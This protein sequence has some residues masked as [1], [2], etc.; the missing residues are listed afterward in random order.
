M[1]PPRRLVSYISHENSMILLFLTSKV[2]EEEKEGWCTYVF[3]Y[4]LPVSHFSYRR[5]VGGLE[6]EILFIKNQILAMP[7][8]IAVWLYLTIYK[9]IQCN[10]L[11]TCLFSN[12]FPSILKEYFSKISFII[13]IASLKRKKDDLRIR[14]TFLKPRCCEPPGHYLCTHE[15]DSDSLLTSHQHTYNTYSR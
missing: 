6:S 15:P 12:H 7:L 8:G 10:Q 11:V 1:T 2:Q 4:S 13:T 5:F 14:S 3:R 9:C